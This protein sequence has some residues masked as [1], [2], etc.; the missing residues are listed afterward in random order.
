MKILIILVRIL[1]LGCIMDEERLTSAINSVL[2]DM[3]R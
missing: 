1:H 2:C 3:D